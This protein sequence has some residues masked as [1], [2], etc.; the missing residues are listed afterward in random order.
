MGWLDARAAAQQGLMGGFLQ[1]R[2]AANAGA[3]PVDQTRTAGEMSAQ[4]KHFEISR[5]MWMDP[6]LQGEAMTPTTSVQ[7]VRH[8][9]SVVA[10]R[11]P[12]VIIRCISFSSSSPLS[13]SLSLSVLPLFLIAASLGGRGCI[14]PAVARE[15]PY[16][17]ACGT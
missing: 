11:S 17:N 7:R 8:S 5:G 15:P 3:S 14:R 13:L 1:I 2:G 9:I 16:G 6:S 12:T 4:K 10:T